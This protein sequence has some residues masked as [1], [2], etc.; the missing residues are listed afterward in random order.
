MQLQRTRTIDY[1]STCASII[2]ISHITYY[3]YINVYLLL[4]NISPS[5]T[6]FFGNWARFSKRAIRVHM[7]IYEYNIYSETHQ[8]ISNTQH[9][10][11]VCSFQCS[12]ALM[13]SPNCQNI[14]CTVYTILMSV[15]DMNEAAGRPGGQQQ[16]WSGCRKKKQMSDVDRT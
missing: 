16:Q 1:V 5:G 3:K 14:L 2:Q 4:P 11:A 6:E 10:Q 13:I 15:V 9:S 7:L 12:T 8:K